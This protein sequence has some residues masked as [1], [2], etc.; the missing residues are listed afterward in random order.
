MPDVPA[1]ASPEVWL[2][3]H[4]VTA[5]NAE[6]RIQGHTDV[7]LS[8]EGRR[9]AE[10]LARRLAASPPARI[11][12]SDLRRALE[13][14]EI[15]GR[16]LGVA[17]EADAALREQDLGRWQ[18]LTGEEARARDPELWA[19]RFLARDPAARPPGGET[20]A[21]LADRVW[22]A[23]LRHAAPGAAGPLLLVTHGGVVASLVY[24]V[25][26]IPLSA[27]RG[28]SLPN[29]ALTTLAAPGG[30]WRIAAMNDASHLPR[31]TGATF[32]FE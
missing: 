31:E 22:R 12:S 2:A 20:R 6:G 8:D 25:L 4:G 1:P 21:E 17:V 5:W 27:P 9:Q 10:A 29:A 13:T 7:P 3:R 26:A 16:A 28:F 30:R 18:G 19:A 15:V 24:R 23:F 32:P 14:A 11:V